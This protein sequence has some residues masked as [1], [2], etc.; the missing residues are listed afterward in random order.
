MTWIKNIKYTEGGKKNMLFK[1]Q[2]VLGMMLTIAVISCQ[3]TNKQTAF[4]R[5]VTDALGRQVQVADTLK[6][7]VTMKAGALRLM[8]YMGLADKIGYVEQNEK[9]RTVPY[10]MANPHLKNLEILGVGNNLDP[11]LLAASKADVIIATYITAAEADDLEKKTRKPVFVLTYG[12]LVER[13]AEFFQSL[14]VLGKLFYRE[15]RADSL[16]QFINTHIEDCK[17][18]TEKFKNAAHTAYI[19]GIAF[20]GAQDITSTRV[21]YPPF[22]FLS[23]KNP[24]DSVSSSL[25][26]IGDGQKNTKIDL[27]QLIHCN[28]DFLFLDAS[29]QKLWAEDMKKPIFNTLKAAKN[30]HIYTVLPF[31]WHS[32][33]FENLL[34]NTWFIGKTVYPD[35]F[36][37]VNPEAKSR[38]I[39][40]FFLGKDV[41]NDLDTLYNPF[42]PYKTQAN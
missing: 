19:G 41:Y 33:N 28:P 5:T 40:Q 37:D 23:I 35:A 32:I 36:K 1:L 6:T 30:N 34:C 29:G 38:E 12:D 11:E 26:E 3:Q 22:Q 8:C 15:S 21:M 4:N 10:M 42:K 31:N 9:K 17:K 7:V 14:T 2:Q 13:K 24:I 25:K 20:N 18:R 39:Y 16:I 27:E